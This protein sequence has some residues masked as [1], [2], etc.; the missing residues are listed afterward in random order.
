MKSSWP[1]Y[2]RELAAIKTMDRAPYRTSEWYAA[3]RRFLQNQLLQVRRIYMENA[4]QLVLP[5]F[6]DG[7]AKKLAESEA[8]SLPFKGIHVTERKA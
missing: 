5:I 2:I 4:G 3:R 7:A 1:D 6:G 8:S